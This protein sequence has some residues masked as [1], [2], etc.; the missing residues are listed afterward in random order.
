MSNIDIMSAVAPTDVD[1]VPTLLSGVASAG[2]SFSESG[3]AVATR[4]ELLA[5]VRALTHALETP[6]EMMIQHVWAQVGQAK[7]CRLPPD[8]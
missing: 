2:H 7:V 5:K 3:G 6:R 4:R 1:A 8:C